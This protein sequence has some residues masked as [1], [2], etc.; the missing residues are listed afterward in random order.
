MWNQASQPARL[1]RNALVKA[2][3]L[4]PAE[5]LSRAQDTRFETKKSA[6]ATIE[7]R[8]TSRPLSGLLRLFGKRTSDSSNAAAVVPESSPQLQKKGKLP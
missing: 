7:V 1:T 3:V 2:P 4:Q 5:N 6:P 8:R